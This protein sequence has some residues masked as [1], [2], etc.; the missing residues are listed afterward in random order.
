MSSWVK[1]G[2]VIAAAVVFGLLFVFF[3]FC[4]DP[5]LKR[6]IVSAGQAAAGAK[7]E[8]GSLRTRLAAGTLEIRSVAVANKNEPMENLF[9]LGAADLR[10]SPGA[11]LRGKAV[12]SLAGLTG[13]QLGTKRKTSGALPRTEPSKM[14]GLIARQL[15]PVKQNFEADL[16]KAKTT[17]DDL[18]PRKLECLKGLDEAKQQLEKTGN[19]LKGQLGVDTIDAQIKE[20]EGQIKQLQM[21]GSAPADIAR[22]A[23]LA[24]DTQKKIKAML[25][26]VE[27]SRDLVRKQFD[28]VQTRLKQ[29]DDLRHKDVNGLLEAAGLPTLDAQSLTRHLLGPESSR[30]L[31]TALYWISWIRQRSASQTKKETIQPPARRRGVNFEFPRS[32][33]YPQF[34]LEKAELAGKVERLY[35]GRD[36]DLSGVLTGVT[37][38]PPLYGQPAKLSLRGVTAAGGP[39]MSLESTLDQ[40]RLPGGMELQLRYAGLPLSGIGLGDDKIGAALTAGLGT[41]N[42]TVRIVGDQWNGT[43][44]LSADNVALTPSVKIAGPAAPFASAAL[45]GIKRFTVTIGISGREDDL[46]FNLSSDLG[47]T[48][49]DGMKKAFS[50]E[51]AK[52]RKALEEKLNA[53]YAG[54]AQEL[55]GQAEAA[56]KQLLAPLDK[57]K[58]KLDEQLKQAVSKGLGGI[59]LPKFKF[60]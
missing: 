19:D 28:V 44:L 27:T 21:G 53:L 45:A 29:A 59:K 56:Q 46:R 50:A 15:A 13:I 49:A 9:E 8:I 39:S 11:A 54:R 57:Q 12:V 30:K 25:K 41:L 42:G 31:S 6:A 1:K 17:A 58:A 2:N 24:A 26:Q 40:T 60:K 43:V 34:L 14:E 55:R 20:I 33:T 7:V 38:N 22:K 3:Y 32:H 37:S 48:L 4:L 5:L 35:Q 18:D 23:Q 36:M 10:F 51:V 16:G 47:Q 52:Q